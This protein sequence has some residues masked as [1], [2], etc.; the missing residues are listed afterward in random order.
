MFLML[1]GFLNALHG[2]E[3]NVPCDIRSS[4]KYAIRKI[5][6]I[7]PLHLVMLIFAFALYVFSARNEI[8]ADIKTRMLTG[9][10]KVLTN[11]FLISDWGPKHG[12]WY[13]IFSE[14][15]IVTWYLSLSLLLFLLTPL[16]LRIMHKVYDYKNNKF[17]LLRPIV[18]S[19]IIYF[20]TILVNLMFVAQFG[21]KGAFL[22]NYE[23]PLSRVGDY[24]IALQVGYIYVVDITREKQKSIKQQE[25]TIYHALLIISIIIS[26]LL[27]FISIMVIGDENSWIV[28]SG[29]YFSIPTAFF[30]YVL[31][32]AEKSFEEHT[33]DQNVMS[34]VVGVLLKIGNIS[35][36][37]FLIHVPIINLVH[38]VYSRITDVNIWI[39]GIISFVLTI[40]LSILAKRN[41]TR[42]C[43][44]TKKS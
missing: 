24:L 41:M 43:V 39:W 44:R 7:Y 23:S 21:K 5:K 1:S 10:I 19:I 34:C 26:V 3:E 2:Y 29:F 38:G 4:I 25:K 31:A 12:W 30:I 20:A 22:Y 17:C 33:E 32:K 36:Y 28:S 35:Q 18:V 16:F 42:V 13:N 8:F 27:L 9:I 11:V 14:Y 40:V 37:A 15:N 6:G